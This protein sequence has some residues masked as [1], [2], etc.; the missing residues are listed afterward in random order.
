MA[1]KADGIEVMAKPEIGGIPAAASHPEPTPKNHAFDDQP[2]QSH[3]HPE[4]GDSVEHGPCDYQSRHVDVETPADH[5]GLDNTEN[6]WDEEDRRKPSHQNGDHAQQGVSQLFEGSDTHDPFLFAQAPEM[7]QEESVVHSMQDPEGNREAEP[8]PDELQQRNP[9]ADVEGGGLFAED[10]IDTDQRPDPESQAYTLLPDEDIPVNGSLNHKHP[11]FPEESSAEPFHDI[12]AAS[13][14]QH[15]S[16]F[17]SAFS[18]IQSHPSD[19]ETS[20]EIV[21]QEIIEFSAPEQIERQVAS[22][23]AQQ[24]RPARELWSSFDAGEEILDLGKVEDERSSDPPLPESQENP[25]GEEVE[26]SGF[27]I[28]GLTGPKGT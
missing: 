11:E 12:F 7:T 28:T 1:D 10:N 23:S 15:N 16:G 5:W 4:N 20:L 9:F 14:T 8:E 13:S 22:E 26:G 18:Q 2:P 19:T 27:D 6:G 21:A 3:D 25:F 17:V 24:N